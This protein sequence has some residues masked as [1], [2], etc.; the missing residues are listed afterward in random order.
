MS[1]CVTGGGGNETTNV[2]NTSSSTSTTNSNLAAQPLASPTASPSTSTATAQPVTLPVLDAFFAQEGFANELKSNLGL[3][4]DQVQRLKTVSREQTSKLREDSTGGRSSAESER[5]AT[6]QIKGIIGPDK[7][8]QLYNFV[9]ARWNGDSSGTAGTAPNSV[10]SDTRIVVNIPAYRMDLFKD[11]RLVKSYKI[12][13]GYP[14]FPLPT[15]RRKADTVIFNP[16]WTVPDEPW[17]ESAN[18]VQAGQKV[19]AGDKLNPLGPAKIP[20][21]LPSLIHG[22]KSPSRIGTF[23]S[24][25]C[26]GLTTPQLNDFIPHLAE[27]AGSNITAE[28]VANNEK[29]KTDTKSVKLNSPVTVDLRYETI[30]VEGGNLHIYRDVYEKGTNTEDNLKKVLGIY[31]VTLEQLSENERKQVEEAL[32][33]MARDAQ[34]NP[35]DPGNNQNQNSNQNKNGNKNSKTSSAGPKVTTTVKGRKEIVI[36]IAALAGKG[37]PDPVD[38]NTGGA[39]SDK[40]STE[41]KKSGSRKGR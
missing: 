22:G 11:G 10:P 21:G 18:K 38:L 9:A 34:G 41:S 15:G 8:N 17:V 12:G 31:G 1:G 19:A 36:P 26:V 40:S 13:I 39:P 35:A 20:I 7:T 14:E 28:D 24:H 32:D 23:A 25:G 2:S 3:T 29:T 5:V 6:E 4:D 30:V 27:L 16:T 37:Y 33:E